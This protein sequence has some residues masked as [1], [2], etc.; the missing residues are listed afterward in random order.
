MKFIVMLDYKKFGFDT[1]EGA[2]NFACMAKASSLHPDLEVKIEVFEDPEE[3]E[4]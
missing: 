1:M 3:E 4:E 2:G